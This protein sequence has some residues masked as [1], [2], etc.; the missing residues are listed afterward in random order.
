ML[1]VLTGTAGLFCLNATVIINSKGVLYSHP[2]FLGIMQSVETVDNHNLLD[3]V[4]ANFTDLKSVPADSG[5]VKP[6][7][8]H[9]PMSIDVNLSHVINNLNCE[10]TCRNFA[11]I[12]CT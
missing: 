3:L 9:P 8:N 10:F 7:T 4:F 12:N 6:D 1:L 5:L 2:R 11:A